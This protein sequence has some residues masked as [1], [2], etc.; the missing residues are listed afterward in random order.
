MKIRTYTILKNE[1]RMLPWFIRHYSPWV[2]EMVFM[3]DRKSDDGTRELLAQTPKA[4]VREWPHD[5]GLDDEAFLAFFN[6]VP[7]REG[8]ADKCDWVA[9]VD[10]DELLHH[11]HMPQFLATTRA[12]VIQA[13]GLA[14]I[15]PNGWPEDDG[16]SQVYDIVKTG[17][18]Q[19]NYDK[20][21]LFRPTSGLQSTI[22]RHFYP[23]QFPKFTGTLS[24]G[25][26]LFH[27]HHLG[28]VAE[29]LA[30]NRANYAAAKDKRFAWN[31]SDATEAN[32]D[33]VGTH[34]WVSQ[35]IQNNALSGV[36]DG[37]GL[38]VQ[39]GC[40][41]NRLAGWKN[42]DAEVDIS[43]P[44][45]YGNGEVEAIFAEH[46]IEHITPA[47]AWNFLCECLRILEPGGVLR[48]AFPDIEHLYF[49]VTDGDDY[50]N[51]VV[52]GGH[53]KSATRREA[54]RCAL[55]C[56]G[57]KAAWSEELLGKVLDI[58]GFKTIRF[59]GYGESAHHSLRN[60]EGHWKVV[61]KQVAAAETGIVEAIK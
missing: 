50:C 7:I 41:G 3:L 21:V 36:V 58:V 47:D 17:L 52:K 55:Q 38:R 27:L 44:L 33:Q 11:P 2:S 49:T 34:A 10:A 60:V 23:G 1:R 61:G 15:N 29:T 8:L 13:R 26:T 32:A 9:T 12:S 30:R 35:A 39:F 37:G 53:G 48:L 45:P 43:K 59:P 42:H 5:T 51:A 20:A 25:I 16:R 6:T 46:V 18:P 4:I 31:Y 56:H 14:L 28:G 24:G 57:H 40:G 19:P 54:I 22:G